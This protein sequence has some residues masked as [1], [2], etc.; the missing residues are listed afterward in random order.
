MTDRQA[1]LNAVLRRKD[2]HAGLLRRALYWA[3]AALITFASNVFL[4]TAFGWDGN[5]ARDILGIIGLPLIV[6]AG[7]KFVHAH[8]PVD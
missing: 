6:I 8:L 1:H 3:W 4:G 7:A 5:P 2:V